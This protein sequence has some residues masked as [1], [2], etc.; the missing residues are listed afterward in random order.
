MCVHKGARSMFLTV[1]CIRL[2]LV[3]FHRARLSALRQIS[4]CSRAMLC[5]IVKCRIPSVK[6][7]CIVRVYL[8]LVK[9]LHVLTQSCVVF[10][11][12][13][14]SVKRREKWRVFL[15]PKNLRR[16]ALNLLIRTWKL[17]AHKNWITKTWSAH[18]VF[19]GEI[20]QPKW[21]RKCPQI[22]LSKN[23]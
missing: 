20:T 3:K 12:L 7:H 5:R 22:W 10:W 2:C 16:T 23:P 9:F 17:E 1:I 15:D 14:S 11:V 8:H 4:S 6:F 13:D 18:N 19:I 21:R